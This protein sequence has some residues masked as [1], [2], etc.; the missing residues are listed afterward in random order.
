[1]VLRRSTPVGILRAANAGLLVFVLALG[2]VVRAVVDNGLGDRMSALLPAGSGLAALLG[3]AAV[4]AVLAN[5]VNNLPATLVLA[6]L[7]APAG[8][9]AVLAVLIGVNI[10]PNLTY[11]GSLSNL[12]WRRVLRRYGVPAGVGEYTRLGLCTV[13]PTLLAAVLALWAGARLLGA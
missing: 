4:A 13:P 8:P 9:V 2:V 3:V 11:A 6:P 12:L 7:V 10:G 1:L 5:L